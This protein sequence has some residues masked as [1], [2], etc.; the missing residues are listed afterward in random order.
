MFLLNCKMFF[1]LMCEEIDRQT[2]L[3]RAANVRESKTL[4]LK[5]LL[6]CFTD[7]SDSLLL[8]VD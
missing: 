2:T 5:P 1:S 4:S 3:G 7:L 6:T 8:T